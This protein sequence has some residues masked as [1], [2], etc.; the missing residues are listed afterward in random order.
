MEIRSTLFLSLLLHI[1]FSA[2]L[3]LS[4]RSQGDGGK[5]LNE[6]VLFVD[7][8][9]DAEKTPEAVTKDAFLKKT[10]VKKMRKE[11]A[12]IAEK[13]DP[14]EDMILKD[15]VSDNIEPS[16][17][18]DSEDN[19]DIAE[20][21]DR[22]FPGERM[23][24]SNSAQDGEEII[25][26]VKTA[27]YKGGGLSKADALKLISAAI[28]RA[29]TYPAIARRRGIE[30]TVYVSFRIG[31]GGEPVEIRVLKSSGSK[32]LDEVTLNV[33]NNAAPYPYID[34]RVEVPVTYRLND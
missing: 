28:E 2:L 17:S 10:V 26:S 21:S 9:A 16:L 3:L 30:G 18:I 31:P 8:K 25:S 5:M 13:R 23:K 6:K 14:D 32:V 12:V 19:S 20:G 24:Y 33:I 27:G 15:F 4:V 22:T 1:T 11:P 7:L 34:D 29:K